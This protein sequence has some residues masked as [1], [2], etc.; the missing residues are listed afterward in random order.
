ML[1]S[2]IN[3]KYL[4]EV[5]PFLAAKSVHMLDYIKPVQRDFDPEVSDTYWYQ[6]PNDRKHWMKS[7]QKYK[8]GKSKQS[9]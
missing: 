5:R 2:S 4:V 9:S 3:H 8:S 1:T 6:R 7:S